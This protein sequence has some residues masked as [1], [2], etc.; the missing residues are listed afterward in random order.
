MRAAMKLRMRWANTSSIDARFA[1]A[2]EYLQDE[3]FA[4]AERAFRIVLQHR[5][6]DAVASL[7]LGTSLAGQGRHAEALAPLRAAAEA[8]PLDAEVHLRLGMSLRKL[9]ESFLAMTALREALKLR[10]G[11]RA[12]EAMLEELVTAARLASEGTSSARV[13]SLRRGVRRRSYHYTR[14]TT[15]ASSRGL[16]VGA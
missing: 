4:E 7:Y 6:N 16:R 3:K 14:R 12:A 8:R 11:L 1:E 10:P 15:P 9:G 5:P 2:W 13:L